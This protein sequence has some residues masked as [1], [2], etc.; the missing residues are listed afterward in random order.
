[1]LDLL[2][3]NIEYPFSLD[4]TYSWVT[5]LQYRDRTDNT[6][7]ERT[8]HELNL[9]TIQSYGLT[10]LNSPTADYVPSLLD[11]QYYSYRVTSQINEVVSSGYKVAEG[12]PNSPYSNFW[13]WRQ[14]TNHYYRNEVLSD[15]LVGEHVWQIRSLS[16]DGATPQDVYCLY[17][18]A[19]GL[20][21]AQTTTTNT[22]TIDV[23]WT[24]GI[25]VTATRPDLATL[26]I[27]D[28]A[29][30]GNVIGTIPISW[31]YSLPAWVPGSPLSN[32][33]FT[34]DISLRA[35]APTGLLQ[36]YIQI[37]LNV[38]RPYLTTTGLSGT[39]AD[40]QPIDELRLFFYGGYNSME[41]NLYDVQDDGWIMHPS[42]TS[43]TDR[44][45]PPGKGYLSDTFNTPAQ[46]FTANAV[47]AV[48]P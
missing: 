42:G 25:R 11:P 40:V 5:A 36:P 9:Y 13:G 6:I 37:D 48:H 7:Q 8:F 10:I 4:P 22:L 30:S 26:T 33:S 3:Q 38:T 24:W 28:A 31:T 19:G 34:S 41:I 39:V 44:L 21:T 29:S 27:R 45:K 47:R 16:A 2:D 1:M 17:T 43:D 23:G 20:A 12:N 15:T 32:P 14:H 35:L 18:G 46:T